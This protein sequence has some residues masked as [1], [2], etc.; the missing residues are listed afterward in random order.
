MS[1]AFSKAQFEALKA[2]ARRTRKERSELTQVQA[3][4]IVATEYG[5]QSWALLARAYNR[6]GANPA[7]I[8][9]PA[10]TKPFVAKIRA[11][12]RSRDRS[13]RNLWWDE[14]VP[15]NQPEA[16]YERFD[17]VPEHLQIADFEEGVV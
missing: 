11:I 3:L 17:W 5:F 14:E 15:A 1:T 16:Y 9:P 12:V 6:S 7:P 4:D 2:R 8:A 13:V 10:L